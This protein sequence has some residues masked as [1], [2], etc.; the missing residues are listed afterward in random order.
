MAGCSVQTDSMGVCFTS[1]LNSA[2]LPSSCP[3]HTA[4]VPQV[5]ATSGTSIPSHLFSSKWL[6]TAE[7]TVVVE[8]CRN[9]SSWKA[10]V[11]KVN[12]DMHIWVSLS[13]GTEFKGE[14]LSEVAHKM[15]KN[16]FD[17]TELHHLKTFKYMELSPYNPSASVLQIWV[18]LYFS[19]SCFFLKFT[20]CHVVC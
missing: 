7:L 13:E 2:A 11:F 19:C 12:I 14:T 6:Q 18:R 20:K 15:K 1:Q 10:T 16:S 5:K 4:D 3:A 9:L 8:E 17:V